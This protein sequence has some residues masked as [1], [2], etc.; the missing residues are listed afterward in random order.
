MNT[1]GVISSSA[2]IEGD[3]LN[4]TGDD[5][6]SGS[7]QIAADISGSLS[8]DAIAALGAGITSGS[9]GLSIAGD[10]G[11]DTTTVGVDT[12]TFAGDNTITATVTD[13]TVTFTAPDGIV[14]ASVLSSPSQGTV[15]QA[16][17]GVNTDVDTGLQTGDS[18]TF[19]GLTISGNV[20]ISGDLQTDGTVTNI[21]TADLNIEDKFILL[22]SGS[23]SGNSGII[24]QNSASNGEGT[25]LFFDDTA[26][27]WSLDYEGA[28]ANTD[29]VTSDAYVAAVAIDKDDANY[30]KDGNIFVSGSGDVFIY[31][32]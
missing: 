9:L 13:N 18:P 16:L 19:A 32:E 23:A 4:T 26:N 28:N 1:E 30:Q 31:V 8:A 20:T 29:A 21:N 3:F 24:A 14:S 2:Q 5:V 11:T 15:R 7:A 25:A 6:L 12:L 27:R 10:S 22:N 17:N